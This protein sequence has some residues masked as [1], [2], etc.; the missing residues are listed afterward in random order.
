LPNPVSTARSSKSQSQLNRL[1]A[2][3]ADDD[4]V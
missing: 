3:L 1:A 2:P 4:Q